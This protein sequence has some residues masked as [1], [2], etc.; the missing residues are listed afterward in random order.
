MIVKDY[1]H[2]LVVQALRDGELVVARTDTLYGVLADAHNE[3]AVQRVYEL[4]QRQADKSL[5][6]LIDQLGQLHDEPDEMMRHHLDVLWPGPYT[7][8]LPAAHA[9]DWLRFHDD[10]VAYR[11]PQHAKLRL[12]LQKV[13]P[14]VAQSA[15]PG[16]LAPAR[17][18]QEAY[19]YFGDAVSVYVDAGEVPEDVEASRL[20]RI[21]NDGTI[22]I[23]R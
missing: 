4:K 12:L 9:P 6:A 8:V 13:G 5:I 3:S 17:S 7:F 23:L 14:M 15:N 19:D 2:P 18:V 1:T 22:E 21:Q 16:G 10:T 20:L 11:M